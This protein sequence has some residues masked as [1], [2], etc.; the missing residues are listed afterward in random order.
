M[1]RVTAAAYTPDDAAADAYDA[2]YAEYK[3]LHDRF[4]R[5]GDDIMKRLKAIRREALSR[6]AVNA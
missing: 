1:G 5:G 4:G 2:L 3:N 6:E